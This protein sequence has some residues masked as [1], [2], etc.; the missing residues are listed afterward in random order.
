MMKDPQQ[1]VRW[2]GAGTNLRPR[3]RNTRL[4]T[5]ES[6]A[7]AAGP[8]DSVQEWGQKIAGA[9]QPAGQP[10]T[11]ETIR[12]KTKKE[13]KRREKKEKKE[14]IE[15]KGKEKEERDEEKNG[16]E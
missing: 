13:R 11:E 10:T 6:T 5:E 9:T 15:R 2:T 14:K 8:E 1:G 16:K 4:P 12:Q 7:G 3:C